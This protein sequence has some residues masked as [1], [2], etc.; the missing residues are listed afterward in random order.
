MTPELITAKVDERSVFDIWQTRFVSEYNRSQQFRQGHTLIAG[1]DP[2][3]WKLTF[4]NNTPPQ[5]IK[6]GNNTVGFVSPNLFT[7]TNI[8]TGETKSLR[9]VCDVYVDRRVRGKGLLG[10]ALAQMREQGVEVIA[11]DRQKI[12]DH[13][14]Y[15]WSLGF[16]W[17]VWWAEHELLL[18]S[19][20]QHSPE[21]FRILPDEL[22][23]E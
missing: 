9:Y 15:Y 16:R 12:E 3:H 18:V 17:A 4:E 19:P 1:T 13:A 2:K 23:T 10:W 21:W 14:G 8:Q 22:E 11:I 7:T 20:T 6:L 5:W